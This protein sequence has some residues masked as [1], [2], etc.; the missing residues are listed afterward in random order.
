MQTALQTLVRMLMPSNGDVVR[1]LRRLGYE[2]HHVQTQLLGHRYHI[3]NLAIDLRDGILLT[4]LVEL[5]LFGTTATQHS[6]PK[7][8]SDTVRNL[9][10]TTSI[11][12]HQRFPLS[13]SLN[14]SSTSRVTK[15]QNVQ[16]ALTPLTGF[17][18]LTP[19]I[20]DIR[21]GDIVD[22]HREKTIKL[23]WA[24]ISQFGLDT[25]L[26]IADLKQE[27]RKLQL[28]TDSNT[29]LLT[30]GDLDNS[31]MTCELLLKTWAGLCAKVKQISVF[32]LSTSFSD[33]KVFAAILDE[34]EPYM[35][36]HSNIT[37]SLSS[38]LLQLGCSTEFSTIFE[39]QQ[40]FSQDF[41]IAALSFLY[42]RL[43]Q[44]TKLCRNAITLQRMWRKR[45]SN[46]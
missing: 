32:N 6:I 11:T 19:I 3:S 44:P 17:D 24:V 45:L 18:S 33:G 25:V 37:M 10:S 30:A 35:L 20:A 38:R 13:Q 34:Y 14:L 40:I 7:A 42:S 29:G 39:Q 27:I 1:Y 43:V 46:V 2:V 41:V 26:D 4:R 21:P 23:L 8:A 22:G 5:L 15:L 16:I 9:K 28:K 12:T 36:G 31:Q